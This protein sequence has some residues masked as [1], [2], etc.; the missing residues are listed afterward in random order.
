MLKSS[1]AIAL[2]LLLYVGLA[3]G[4]PQ[5]EANQAMDTAIAAAEFAATEVAAT[6]IHSTPAVP[7]N[8]IADTQANLNLIWTMIAAILVFLMQAGFALVETG[9]TRSKNAVNIIMKNIMDVSAGCLVFFSRL[10][11]V[12]CL[13][14][15]QQDGSERTDFY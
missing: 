4:S 2:F 13:E 8:Q 9:L 10:D 12:S 7:D 3:V 15:P 1:G 14:R 11:S 6:V 5:A